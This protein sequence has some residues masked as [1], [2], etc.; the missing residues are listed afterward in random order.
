MNNFLPGIFNI[1]IFYIILLLQLDYNYIY[2]LQN[3]ILDDFCCILFYIYNI[4]KCTKCKG[5]SKKC[6][7]FV[8]IMAVFQNW[9][10]TLKIYSLRYVYYRF[11]ALAVNFGTQ[12]IFWT[13][14]KNVHRRV[15]SQS[16]LNVFAHTSDLSPNLMTLPSLSQ[17]RV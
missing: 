4:F 8:N 7:I 13:C 5:K 10:P 16:P 2:L 14:G 9:L 3:F 1:Y 12:P 11:S 6:V 17:R 15:S